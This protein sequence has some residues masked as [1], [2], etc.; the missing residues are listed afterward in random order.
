MVCPLIG[1]S[2][3]GSA[4]NGIVLIGL[5]ALQGEG[6]RRVV[7]RKLGGVVAVAGQVQLPSKE[8]ISPSFL[9]SFVILDFQTQSFGSLHSPYFTHSKAYVPL[10]VLDGAVAKDAERDAG[11]VP[12]QPLTV[13][14]GADEGIGDPELVEVLD[15][16][17]VRKLFVVVNQP[18]IE[19]GLLHVQIEQILDRIKIF[20]A[21]CTFAINL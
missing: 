11:G 20:L 19:P 7:E 6:T 15:S 1:S 12:D 17:Q 10:G 2:P 21:S 8:N 5:T 9:M 16:V 13:H 4:G 14:G 18:G 3:I